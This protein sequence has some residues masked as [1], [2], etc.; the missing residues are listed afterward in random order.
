MSRRGIVNSLVAAVAIL[1]T[2]GL[3]AQAVVRGP[4]TSADSELVA[5]GVDGRGAFAIDPRAATN[6]TRPTANTQPRPLPRLTTTTPQAP[7]TT[8]T[9]V[10][11]PPETTI[12]PATLAP[13]T[14]PP[15]TAPPAAVPPGASCIP[16][17][18]ERRPPPAVAPSWTVT[19]NGV[20]LNVRIEPA[21]P[22]IGETVTIFYEAT[23]SEG[24]CC[25]F[26]LS[27]PDQTIREDP[28]TGPGCPPESAAASG[29][30][31]VVM[32]RAGYYGFRLAANDYH[33]CQPPTK[34]AYG[35]ELNASFWVN[36]L[37]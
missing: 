36:P 32:T 35:V 34:Q 19:E 23:G 8:A 18:W 7:V 20:T 28:F 2:G 13:V 22:V 6:D 31:T 25:R 9:T 5:A 30:S 26:G 16:I 11:V 21:A 4:S 29:S 1:I 10:P 15:E 14:A 12:P 37:P 3:A 27:D 17:C 33:L 24:Y